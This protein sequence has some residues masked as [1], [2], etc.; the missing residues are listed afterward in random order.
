[1]P[2]QAQRPRIPET[3]ENQRKA[4]LAWNSGKTGKGKPMVISPVVERCTADGCG[5]T[6]DQPGMVL[7]PAAGQEPGR[8]YCPGRCTAIGRALTDLRTGGE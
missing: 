4:R 5:T 7:V 3:S 6:A 1:M 2:T 8:W